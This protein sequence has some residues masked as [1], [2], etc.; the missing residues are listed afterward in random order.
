MGSA[1]S[2]RVPLSEE[3]ETCVQNGSL[4]SLLMKRRANDNT[5]IFLD[6]D[7]SA[8][9]SQWGSYKYRFQLAPDIPKNDCCLYLFFPNH[10]EPYK[11]LL[12]AT[13]CR[14]SVSKLNIELNKRIA[15]SR[16]YPSGV[17]RLQVAILY[18]N[19]AYFVRSVEGTLYIYWSEA[20]TR[21]H[22]N[23]IQTNL[24]EY[25]PILF[26]MSGSWEYRGIVPLQ[27]HLEQGNSIELLPKEWC[28]L[29]DPLGV[30]FPCEMDIRQKKDHGIT[31][32]SQNAARKW[33]SAN[34]AQ[35][36]KEEDGKFNMSQLEY[37][38]VRPLQDPLLPNNEKEEEEEEEEG[39]EE[40]C[41]TNEDVG[42]ED[43]EQI[44]DAESS[45]VVIT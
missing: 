17:K 43:N 45:A 2:A 16:S 7:P 39:E 5:I 9:I 32:L 41:I 42:C 26:S 29:A 3:L 13:D 44:L 20:S 22:P 21:I 23:G 38:S 8:S 40:L 15:K 25:M 4:E 33:A 18:G 37:R 6:L 24:P 1:A 31:Y 35:E 34:V 28:E 14:N 30:Y 19:H 12:R 11:R 27:S 10:P 36:M